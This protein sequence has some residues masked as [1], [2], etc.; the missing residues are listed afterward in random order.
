MCLLLFPNLWLLWAIEASD[1]P[2]SL[3]SVAP[4]PAMDDHTSPQYH[5]PTFLVVCLY[6]GPHPPRPAWLLLSVSCLAYDIYG[7]IT[8]LY[9]HDRE[10]PLHF[11][12]DAIVGKRVFP[13]YF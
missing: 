1:D 8:A 3:F 7:Q 11:V 2:S 9:V 12:P 13:A 10:Y 6:V 4:L 5:P